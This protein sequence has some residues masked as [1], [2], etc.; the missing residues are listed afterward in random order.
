MSRFKNQHTNMF[1]FKQNTKR[2]I[3]IWR[4]CSVLL[5]ASNSFTAGNFMVLWYIH[6]NMYNNFPLPEHNQFG[7]ELQ[8]VLYWVV[9]CV[10]LYVQLSRSLIYV[11]KSMR[12]H[13]RLNSGK[14]TLSNQCVWSG[15]YPFY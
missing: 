7:T 9:P 8:H 2:K 13:C 12:G 3:S 15:M 5:M 1:T 6:I 14:S 10:R 11:A 4:F